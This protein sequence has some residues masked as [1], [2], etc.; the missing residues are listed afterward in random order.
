MPA[1]FFIWERCGGIGIDISP[2][3]C[4][5]MAKRLRDVCALPES[6]PLW[7]AGR[8]FIVR[9]LPWTEEKLRAIP[10]FEFENWAVIT[11]GG[12]PNKVQVGDMGIDGRIFPIHAM[13]GKRG[14][15]TGELEFTDIWFP[16]QV[17]QKDKVGRPDIDSFEA[18]MIRE[19][20]TLGYFVGFDFSK[21]ALEEI[22]GFQKRQGLTIKPLTVRELLET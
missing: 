13:P 10:P 12:K 18:V 3:A 20:R 21:D 2:T 5:V 8:G 19:R 1:R 17:K 11:L 9:D 4:R 15:A 7:R 16:I 6:E 22:D 14:S